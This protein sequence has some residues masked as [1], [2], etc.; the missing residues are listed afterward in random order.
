[1]YSDE[2]TIEWWKDTD[3]VEEIYCWDTV[4]NRW[5]GKSSVE[6]IINQNT[7][8]AGEQMDNAV[9]MATHLPAL[10]SR[11]DS[12]TTKVEKMRDISDYVECEVCGS[13]VNK[14]KAQVFSSV[15]SY[16]DFSFNIMKGFIPDNTK[17]AVLHYVCNH[18]DAKK[19]EKELKKGS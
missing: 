6:L 4:N 2:L 8:T 15:K 17:Q 12:L 16:A 9:K 11:V 13:L 10:Q 1:M 3:I 19:Y 18:C 14:S 5:L 7:M